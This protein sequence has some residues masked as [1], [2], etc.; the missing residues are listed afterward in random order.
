MPAWAGD[1]ACGIEAKCALICASI[2]ALS[3]SP[4]AMTAIRSGRYQSA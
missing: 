1:D 2:A 3:K 4:T